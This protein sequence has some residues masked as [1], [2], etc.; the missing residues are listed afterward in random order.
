[1]AITKLNASSPLVLVGRQTGLTI[2]PAQ[3]P[4][5]RL[6]YFDGKFLRAVDLQT[7]QNYLRQL[8][9]LSNQAN[10]FGVV[11]GFNL[12]LGG[13]DQLTL[14][15]G[16]AIDPRGRVLLLGQEQSVGIQELIDGSRE[17]QRLL[18]SSTLKATGGFAECELAT[19][20]PTTA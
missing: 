9:N 20:A 18:Q 11:N 16:L 6:N 5:T 4:L 15:A 7:E 17:L 8:T 19:A 1:M 12:T 10:G 3:T 14:G 2:I 13:G